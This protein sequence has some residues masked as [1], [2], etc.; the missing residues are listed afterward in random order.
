MRCLY[1][2]LWALTLCENCLQYIFHAAQQSTGHHV[3]SKQRQSSSETV[4][5]FFKF[6]FIYRRWISIEDTLSI[7]I[8][9]PR[10]SWQ[11]FWS[12]AFKPCLP[13]AVVEAAIESN[14]HWKPTLEKQQMKRSVLLIL[15]L[16]NW[17]SMPLC[18]SSRT[19]TKESWYLLL[20]NFRILFSLGI[21]IWDLRS[22][23]FDIDLFRIR[24]PTTVA[25]FLLILVAIPLTSSQAGCV[26]GRHNS[27]GGDL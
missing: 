6:Y 25:C 9:W 23:S 21:W 8:T 16:S 22:K 24:M 14:Q 7:F 19:K 4:F 5:F 27:Y 15:K 20:L 12:L 3:C 1:L 18:D 13:K 17:A 2:Q 26:A 11:Q 10:S